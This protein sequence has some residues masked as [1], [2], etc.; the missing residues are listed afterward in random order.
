MSESVSIQRKPE[1][2]YIQLIK[3]ES[4][5][6]LSIPKRKP[7]IYL[8]YREFYRFFYFRCRST[9]TLPYRKKNTENPVIKMSQSHFS[10]MELLFSS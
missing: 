6:S 10:F 1:K 8:I 5:L 7:T 9:L 2:F 3:S 4:M